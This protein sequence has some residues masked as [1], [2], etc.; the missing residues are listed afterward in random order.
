MNW[1]GPMAIEVSVRTVTV[2]ATVSPMV[3]GGLTAT[4]TVLVSARIAAWAELHRRSGSEPATG[5]VDLRPPGR[6]P[7]GR[8]D[9]GN[10]W[11]VGELVRAGGT[12]GE[13]PDGERDGDGACRGPAGLTAV[14]SVLDT[15]FT[16]V[17]WTDPNSTSACGSIDDVGSARHSTA[18]PAHTTRR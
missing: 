16:L 8:R 2:M 4:I 5:D 13:R 15:T 3:P 9:T 7:T 6:E 11:P 12:R 17:A 10:G 1:F 18:F 14:I